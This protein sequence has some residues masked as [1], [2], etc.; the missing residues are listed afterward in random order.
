MAGRMFDGIVRMDE[1]FY[2]SLAKMV[3]E[4]PVLARDRAMMGMLRELGLEKGKSFSPDAAAQA[5]L[6]RG[7]R[8]AH[9]WLKNRLLTYS[10]PYCARQPLEYT[11]ASRRHR[12]GIFF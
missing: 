3:N 10:T 8:E 1:S 4:E 5:G 9:E 11:S 2:V 12:D 6:K 7:I